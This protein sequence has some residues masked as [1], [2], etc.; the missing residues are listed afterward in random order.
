MDGITAEAYYTTY[1]WAYSISSPQK[2]GT[3]FT[4]L[5]KY[6]IF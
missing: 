5:S 3:V 1:A 2:K 6:S 4:T